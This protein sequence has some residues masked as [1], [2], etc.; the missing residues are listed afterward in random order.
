M[1]R[2]I[3]VWFCIQLF[4]DRKVVWPCG[5]KV[6]TWTFQ[7]LTFCMLTEGKKRQCVFPN[8]SRSYSRVGIQSHLCIICLRASKK[9]VES[10]KLDLL[11]FGWNIFLKIWETWRKV[12]RK[13]TIN[14]KENCIWSL[15]SYFLTN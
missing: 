13:V 15:L 3:T 4:F 14:T 11:K 1:A 2:T 8:W 6:D 9:N 7:Q 12:R 5:Q 10:I